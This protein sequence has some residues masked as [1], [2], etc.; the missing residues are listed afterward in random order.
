MAAN[1]KNKKHTDSINATNAVMCYTVLTCANSW[2]NILS[3][4]A[5]FAKKLC[6]F[7]NQCT[8]RS[9]ILKCYCTTFTPLYFNVMCDWLL[10]NLLHD[11]RWDVVL[12]IQSQ[13][14]KELHVSEQFDWWSPVVIEHPARRWVRLA[15]GLDTE[16]DTDRLQYQLHC[17]RRILTSHH[18]SGICYSIWYQLISCQYILA[19]RRNS[20][21]EYE[22]LA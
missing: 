7:A 6:A 2:Y 11:S 12:V 14:I 16:H 19:K 20:T 5:N 13:P 21:N 15:V 17:W 10:S 22:A 9:N 8:N 18:H 3:H 4:K 1:K